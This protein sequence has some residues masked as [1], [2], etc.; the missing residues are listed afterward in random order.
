MKKKSAKPLSKKQQASKDFATA[1][2]LAMRRAARAARKTA[3]FHGTP[4]VVWRD[5]KVVAIKP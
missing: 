4:I 5:G 2:G 3:R 1:V